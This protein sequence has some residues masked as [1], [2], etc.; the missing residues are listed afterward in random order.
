[1]A[2][3]SPTRLALRSKRENMAG[4]SSLFV[5]SLEANLFA[6]GVCQRLKNTV[7]L[8]QDGF[9]PGE[10][11]INPNLRFGV[12]FVEFDLLPFDF[13]QSFGGFGAL[14]E[15][16]RLRMH[17]DAPGLNERRQRLIQLPVALLFRA[18]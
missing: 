5:G 14:S 3:I 10:A 17:H 4:G 9:N 13:L 2:R 12:F 7:V 8:D 15:K 18:R 11:F 6:N 16:R 1:M